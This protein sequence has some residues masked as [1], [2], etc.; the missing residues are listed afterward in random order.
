MTSPAAPP[1][2]ENVSDAAR[3][4]APRDWLSKISRGWRGPLIAALFT[5]VAALPG[6][7]A[8]PPLD[9]DESRFAQ[10]TAQMLETG[11]FV[12]IR[13]QD[14]PRDK[15][16]V[17][18]HWLQ[19]L[20]V[21][22][23]SRVEAR[24]I[25]AYR[26]PSLLGASLAAAALTWFAGAALGPRT[27]VIAG[28]LFG[29]GVLLTT[30]AFIAKT[31][32]VLCG[33]TT[34]AMAA[35]GRVYLASRRGE[36]VRKAWVTFFWLGLAVSI[37]VK[38]PIG[39][40]VAGLAFLALWGLDRTLAWTARL[41]WI[42]GLGLVVLV[43]GP[44]AMAITVATDGRFWGAAV[45]GDLAPKLHG[46]HESHGAWPGF[47]TL[48][49]PVLLFPAT[50]LLPA[51]LAVL[52][53]KRQDPLLR[54]ALAWALPAWLVFEAT[55]TKL[56]HYPLPT[57][58]ALALAMAAS[59]HDGFGRATAWVGAALSLG[60]GALIAALPLVTNGR[61][62]SP[63]LTPLAGVVAA[64]ALAAGV[65]GAVAVLSQRK[66]PRRF[67][68]ALTL[69]LG[70]GVLAHGAMAGGLAPQLRPIWVSQEAAR[71]IASHHLDPRDGVTEG[72]IVVAGYAEP[73]LVF[74]LG[75]ATELGD[76]AD[77]VEGLSEGQ[78]ALIEGREAATFQRLLRSER[79]AA[80]RVGAVSGLNTSTGKQVT[81][82]LWRAAPGTGE[83]P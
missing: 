64:L 27:G 56:I 36:A 39:P 38:G 12:N 77:A 57:Y 28:A 3:P 13:Y 25:W 30:E 75:T 53:R 32:A 15:K 19:A 11:D 43:V 17:G 23:V 7:L 22:S 31:D 5:V 65:A 2:S 78:P 6:L 10:A 49:A 16:P 1:A 26:L 8:L 55:P 40:M 83:M 73:S 58:G 81:L 20:S 34:L 45:G 69:A 18:I 41:N 42:F 29:S 80:V 59:L 82:E 46:G 79:V 62:G 61:F 21:A 63:G 50:A 52:W 51:A 71:L 74:Q 14:A 4:V 54:F 35:L 76:A 37:L 72:P 70:L 44:W 67:E 66:A 33:A 48:L 68:I 9:R 60:V 24:A 47:H